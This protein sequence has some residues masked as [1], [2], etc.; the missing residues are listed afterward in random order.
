[1]KL[2]LYE[3]DYVGYLKLNPYEWEYDGRYPRVSHYLSFEP[4]LKK[5]VATPD[6]DGET[7]ITDEEEYLNYMARYLKDRGIMITKLIENG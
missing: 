6:S 7:V 1:M 5:G 4:T 2:E 3:P